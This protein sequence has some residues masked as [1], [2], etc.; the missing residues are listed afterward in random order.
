[1]RGVQRGDLQLRRATRRAATK[2]LQ[3]PHRIRYRSP[4]EGVPGVGSGVLRALQRFL[5]P[6]SLRWGAAPGAPGPRPHREGPAVR[7]AR[8]PAAFLGLG[9][10]GAVRD[11]RLPGAPR[12]RS[13]GGRFREV[14]GPRPVPRDVL[15][16]HRFVSECGL[17][18]GRA[19]WQLPAGEVLGRALPPARAER[20]LDPGGEGKTPGPPR[21]RGPAPSAR[22]RAGQRPARAAECIP[23]ACWPSRRAVDRASTPTPSRSPAARRTKSR[24]PGGSPST[25]TGA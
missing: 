13:G 12:A 18:V 16:G 4:V 7:D 11:V 3:V 17:R 10:Q 22:R 25:I 8:H 6:Q 5:G 23:R 21:R 9:D 1:M 20:H 24:S 2:G 15:R 14:A 19:R